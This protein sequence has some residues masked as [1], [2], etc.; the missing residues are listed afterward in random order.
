MLF[1]F[2]QTNPSIDLG[3]DSTV[4]ARRIEN[5][6]DLTVSVQQQLIDKNAKMIQANLRPPLN[7][8]NSKLNV[9]RSLQKNGFEIVT[10]EERSTS[11]PDF[12]EEPPI[13]I[14]KFESNPKFA[15]LWDIYK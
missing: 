11:S 4:F 8:E 15:H 10:K 6:Y 9:I 12:L 14:C 2:P 7:D 1:S 5:E 13:V 3:V